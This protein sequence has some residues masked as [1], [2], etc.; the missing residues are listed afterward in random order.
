MKK[1]AV[2]LLA[3]NCAFLLAVATPTRAAV[4]NVVCN[5]GPEAPQVYMAGWRLM[6]NV[7]W[8]FEKNARGKVLS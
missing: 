1:Q 8:E 4:T 2:Q 7:A 5:V 6:L 3:G